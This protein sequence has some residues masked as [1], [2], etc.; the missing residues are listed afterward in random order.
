MDGSNPHLQTGRAG[1]KPPYHCVPQEFTLPS[2][3]PCS[4]VGTECDIL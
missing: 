2:A 3:R 4:M 1:A